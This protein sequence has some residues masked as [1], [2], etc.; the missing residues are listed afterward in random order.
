MSINSKIV[1]P[2]GAPGTHYLSINAWDAGEQTLYGSGDIAIADCRRTGPLKDTTAA[3]VAG[4]TAGVIPKIIVNAAH[5]HEGKI[6]DQRADSNY[7]YTCKQ[8]ALRTASAELIGAV[9]EGA[10]ISA[11]FDNRSTS[12]F[13]VIANNI[14]HSYSNGGN[15]DAIYMEGFTENTLIYNNIIANMSC[16]IS[17]FTAR[18]ASGITTTKKQYIY[19]N[20]IYN[21]TSADAES[22]GAYGIKSSDATAVIKNNICMNVS[23]VAGTA[24]CF[25]VAGSLSDYNVS[26][27]ATAPG[28]NKATGKTAYTDYF[29][30]HANGDFHL[31]NTSLALFGLSGADL[32]ATFTT[33]IDGVTRSAPWDIGADQYI[34]AGGGSF[35]GTYAAIQAIQQQSIISALSFSGSSSQIQA[36]NTEALAAILSFSGEIGQIQAIQAQ[37]IFQAL[38]IT[39]VIDQSQA[40]QI[41]SL[42][43]ALSFSGSLNQSQNAQ[44]EALA[45][46]LSFA[47]ATQQAQEAQ[48]EVL[49]GLLSF[50]GNVTQAQRIQIETL[51]AILAFSGGIEQTQEQ[52]RQLILEFIAAIVFGFGFKLQPEVKGYILPRETRGFKL[53]VENRGYK[54]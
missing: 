54:V 46:V 22:T 17:A 43:A 48:T 44:I 5:W 9:V 45:S 15:A 28:T 36:A 20:T 37:A 6:A 50:G 16:P 52:Q 14:V 23:T 18:Q 53:P 39:G 19:N 34:A 38:L 51:T 1:D 12:T 3:T 40:A 42:T 35:T 41:A 13:I 47:G 11:L 27:D 26:S 7:I 31:K 2:N 30:D 24:A 25:S 29:A 32:S 49:E 8:V 10:N 4:W 33:D 21:I